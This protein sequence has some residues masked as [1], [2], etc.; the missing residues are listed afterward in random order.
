MERKAFGSDTALVPGYHDLHR[1]H[2]PHYSPAPT[3]CHP[4][5][6]TCSAQEHKY[7]SVAF[8]PLKDIQTDTTT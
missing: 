8:P 3:L 2:T 1:A 7:Y 6:I 5:S 4:V